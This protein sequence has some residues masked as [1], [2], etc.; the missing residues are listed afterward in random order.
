KFERVMVDRSPRW[1]GALE[2]LPALCRVEAGSVFA[3]PTDAFDLVTAFFVTES[4][5]M[6]RREFRVATRALLDS[7]RPGGVAVIAHMVRSLGY[8]AGEGRFPA[9]HLTRDDLE[10]TYRDAEVDFRLHVTGDG[11]N[12]PRDGYEGIAIV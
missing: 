1:Q 10:E 7:V 8:P 12:D 6:S 3:L 2:R 4:I 5:T 11:G 9:V